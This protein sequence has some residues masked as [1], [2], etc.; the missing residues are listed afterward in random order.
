[1]SSEP[2][3]RTCREAWNRFYQEHGLRAAASR[4]SVDDWISSSRETIEELETLVGAPLR[5]KRILDLGCGPG[6][7]IGTFVSSFDHVTG[8]DVSDEAIRL[9]RQR[10]GDVANCSLIRGGV[11]D[12]AAMEAAEFDVIV[13][14][15]TFQHVPDRDEIIRYIR[16][17]DRLLVGGGVAILEIAMGGIVR[18]LRDRAIDSARLSAQ[19]LGMASPGSNL[20]LPAG[21]PYWRGARLSSDDL[22]AALGDLAHDCRIAHGAIKSWVILT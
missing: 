10:L 18:E 11:E 6:R 5:G 8:V 12:L 14:V 20:A 3:I 4:A 7:L 9:C 13:S 15:S 21:D 17:C 16:E 19:R 1:M 2:T 22:E